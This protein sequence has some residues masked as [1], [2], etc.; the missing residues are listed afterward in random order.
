[1]LSFLSNPIFKLLNIILVEYFLD[2]F[3]L[4]TQSEARAQTKVRLEGQAAFKSFDDPFANMESDSMTVLIHGL[5]V[6]ISGSKIRLK[7]ILL[8]LLIHTDAQVFDLYFNL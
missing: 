8:V 3:S 4:K 1:M 5:V 6:C 7:Q 2:Q